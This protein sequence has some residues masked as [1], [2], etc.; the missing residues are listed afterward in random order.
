MS[1][2]SVT[3]SFF[4]KS[5]PF[6]PP[7]P[8]GEPICGL[9]VSLTDWPRLE[10]GLGAVWPLTDSFAT[11]RRDA[12]DRHA[13]DV[14]RSRDNAWQPFICNEVSREG[15]RTLHTLGHRERGLAIFI[16]AKPRTS[17]PLR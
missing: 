13:M 16:N 12:L 14:S 1:H 11:S 4:A 2:R 15:G 8:G 17:L 3:Y 10:E 6:W 9:T 5:F 7:G